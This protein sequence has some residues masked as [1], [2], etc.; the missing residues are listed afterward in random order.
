MT[1][2]SVSSLLSDIPRTLKVVR[3]CRFTRLYIVSLYTYNVS[4]DRSPW[5]HAVWVALDEY[6]ATI[7]MTRMFFCIYNSRWSFKR[8]LCITLCGTFVC[9]FCLERRVFQQAQIQLQEEEMIKLVNQKFS[10]FFNLSRV[11]FH[12]YM[13][14]RKFASHIFSLFLAILRWNPQFGRFLTLRAQMNSLWRKVSR[15]H[16]RVML[17]DISLGVKFSFLVK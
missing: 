7:I 9:G 15:P 14:G 5:K 2:C 13:V 8:P 3:T 11:D 12:L 16:I 17:S 4:F 6:M 1:R 10:S